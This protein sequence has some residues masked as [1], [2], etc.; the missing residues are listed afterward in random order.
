MELVFEMDS[1]L[2]SAHYCERRARH[3]LKSDQFSDAIDYFQAA[4]D[5]MEAALTELD[6]DDPSLVIVNVQISA[7]QKDLART[8]LRKHSTENLPLHL[9]LGKTSYEDDLKSTAASSND[10][11]TANH[12]VSKLSKNDQQ[13]KEEMQMCIL[14]LRRLV[15]TLATKCE[16]TRC[17]LAEERAKR[18]V[19][20]AELMATR[21]YNYYLPHS[22]GP[23][24]IR[25]WDAEQA[26]GAAD[27]HLS[28]FYS[29][30]RFVEDR[31]CTPVEVDGIESQSDV[32]FDAN[33]R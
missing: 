31:P 4:L 10:S 27:Y 29:P 14:E 15:D 30:E 32:W 20:E 1:N 23:N 13:S 3:F 33:N 5:S 11:S 8:I 12:S 2:S 26:S 17:K 25:E 6:E 9:S 7:L 24:T 28:P 18:V 16:V 19:A 21:S 22:P